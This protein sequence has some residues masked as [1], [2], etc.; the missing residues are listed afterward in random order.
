MSLQRCGVS[1]E[2][3]RLI[4]NI[5]VQFSRKQHCSVIIPNLLQINYNS[6]QAPIKVKCLLLMYSE[7]P[8]RS[9]LFSCLL[10]YGT[11]YANAFLSIGP[12]AMFSILCLLPPDALQVI[13]SIISKAE[14]N[15][16]RAC[17]VKFIRIWK[18]F[19][20]FL[21]RYDYISIPIC[22]TLLIL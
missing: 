16:T 8:S 18:L 1:H 19:L 12:H 9:F 20:K 3:K 4:R 13:Y 15:W 14:M 5:V 22:T 17:P 11:L 6:I 10:P 7:A 21:K 2:S